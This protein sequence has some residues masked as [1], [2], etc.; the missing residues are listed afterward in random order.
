MSTSRVMFRIGTALAV[1]LE[2][3]VE[4]PRRGRVG[5]QGEHGPGAMD[6]GVIR[7]NTF[8]VDQAT[9]MHTGGHRG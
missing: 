7:N 4:S 3:G 5:S 2:E 6:S 9:P 8:K 1:F